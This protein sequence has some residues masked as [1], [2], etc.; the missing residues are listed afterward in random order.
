MVYLS[1]S[2]MRWNQ[3]T[4][5]NQV[6]KTE[7]LTLHCRLNHGNHDYYIGNTI[8]FAVDIVNNT[9]QTV[10]NLIYH[11]TLPDVVKPDDSK[12]FMVTASAGKIIYQ[13][14]C[15]IIVIDEIK[16]NDIVRVFIRG[17]IN[18]LW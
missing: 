12:Q 7:P 8:E 11:Q 6:P 14:E 18:N 16:G 13:D 10:Y 3:V 4:E 5:A 15:I 17:R 9:P 2:I 1:Y